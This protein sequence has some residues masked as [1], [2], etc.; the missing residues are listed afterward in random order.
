MGKQTTRG[1]QPQGL[2]APIR[3]K[4]IICSG[5]AMVKL[6]DRIA[7]IKTHPGWFGVSRNCKY[8]PFGVDPFTV[9]MVVVGKHFTCL[10]VVV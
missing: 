3:G 10:F 5:V 9:Y 7:T 6:A 1:T 8:L 4:L 2:K